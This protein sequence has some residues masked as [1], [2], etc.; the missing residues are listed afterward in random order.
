[1]YIHCRKNNG[2]NTFSALC[3]GDESVSFV[4]ASTTIEKALAR[5]EQMEDSERNETYV[6][7]ICWQTLGSYARGIQLDGE[8][9]CLCGG[10]GWIATALQW[11]PNA[12]LVGDPFTLAVGCR[13]NGKWFSDERGYPFISSDV[14]GLLAGIK[15]C[16]VESPKPDDCEF[17]TRTFLDWASDNN[18]VIVEG[19]AYDIRHA[20]LSHPWTQEMLFGK[21][22][23][24]AILGK[25]GEFNDTRGV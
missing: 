14:P 3:V 22:P 12:N 9:V 21:D 18:Y 6:E 8:F 5:Q 17:V 13:V 15:S 16:T 25:L 19:T 20:M 11:T 2:P 4:V 7:S 10:A 1:V 24:E 23:E